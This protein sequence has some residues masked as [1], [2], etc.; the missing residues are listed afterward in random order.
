MKCTGKNCETCARMRET[1]AKA[2][3]FKAA[4]D[5]AIKRKNDSWER[6]DTDGFL[7]QWAS[8]W[9]SRENDS[10]AA[11]AAAGGVAS[12]TVLV[13]KAGEVVADRSFGNR[14]GSYSW[15]LYAEAEEIH[16]RA[17]VPTGENSRIQ[18]SLGLHEESRL[19]WAH[20]KLDGNGTG[21]SGN[22]WLVTFPERDEDYKM[23]II[24]E[25]HAAFDELEEKA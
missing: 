7:S 10:K 15:R 14:F 8:E 24:D 20:V 21:L 22:V 3:V 23:T 4:A 6:S 2:E 16:G 12:F 11:I 9:T 18:K 17:F 13:D 25:G 1:A 19:G 5:E